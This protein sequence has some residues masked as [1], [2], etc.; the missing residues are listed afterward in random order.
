MT[1]VMWWQAGI[2]HRKGGRQKTPNLA[3]EGA[4]VWG[5]RM[6]PSQQPTWTASRAAEAGGSLVGAAAAGGE[7]GMRAHV[8][9]S[10][11]GKRRGEGAVGGVVGVEVVGSVRF[12]HFTFLLSVLLPVKC[13]I[14]FIHVA[15]MIYGPECMQQH[16]HSQL[17]CP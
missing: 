3:L 10:R 17:L 4:N 8:P 15:L 6:T 5:S 2:Q 13:L 14:G 1:G 9:E 16:C 12:V 7:P 11:A